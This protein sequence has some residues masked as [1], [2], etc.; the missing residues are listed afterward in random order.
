NHALRAVDLKAKTVTTLAG[1][2]QQ[3]RR[4]TGSG[5]GKTTSLNSPW[6]VILAPGTRSLFIAMAGPHQIWRYD[7]DSGIIGVWAG[8]GEENI[9]DGTLTAAAFAQPSGLAT[10]GT[11]LYVADSE[12]SGVRSISLDKRNQRVSTIVGMGL[13]A[14]DDIDGVG[15]EVRLQ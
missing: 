9:V 6:D 15:D 7:M 12:V 5:P 1:N 11:H 14:F 13:F 8:S 4:H 2:G 10:D 3:S